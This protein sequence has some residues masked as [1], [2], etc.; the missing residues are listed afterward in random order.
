MEQF[1]IYVTWQWT[2]DNA[3]VLHIWYLAVNWWQCDSSAYMIPGSELVTM[4]QFCIYDTWQWTGDNATVLHIWYLT[5][6][7][8]Q[9]DSSAYMIPG[10]EVEMMRWFFMDGMWQWARDDAIVL[11]GWYV[12]VNWIQ[13]NSSVRLHYKALVMHNYSHYILIGNI[14]LYIWLN[15]NHFEMF[16]KQNSHKKFFCVLKYEC[17]TFLE[18]LIDITKNVKQGSLAWSRDSIRDFWVE[19]TTSPRYII[20]D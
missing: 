10:S 13:D 15:T 5:L 17:K 6:N 1:C 7:W 2:G 20:R 3:T 9:C 12:T 16:L 11:Y 8:L 18:G 14:P 4:R 19:V